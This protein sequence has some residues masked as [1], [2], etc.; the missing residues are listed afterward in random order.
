MSFAETP[1]LVRL[2]VNRA[3]VRKKRVSGLCGGNL[4]I[5]FQCFGP[6]IRYSELDNVGGSFDTRIRW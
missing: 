1:L 3:G 4:V 6:L 2:R 5:F